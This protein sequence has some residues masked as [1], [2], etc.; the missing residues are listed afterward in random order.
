M[1]DN[2]NLLLI[3]RIRLRLHLRKADTGLTDISIYKIK[4]IKNSPAISSS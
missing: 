4:R 3:L 1:L 2:K